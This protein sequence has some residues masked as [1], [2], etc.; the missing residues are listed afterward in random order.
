MLEMKKY[1]IK[2]KHKLLNL[3]IKPHVSLRSSLSLS[4][5]YQQQYFSLSLRVKLWTKSQTRYMKLLASE[6][7][8]VVVI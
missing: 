1:T 6:S 3:T 2:N 8:D 5:V 4:S 7:Y